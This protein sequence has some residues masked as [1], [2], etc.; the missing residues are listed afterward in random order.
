M[1]N[2]NSFHDGSSQNDEICIT[3]KM[4]W[5]TS[6]PHSWLTI[7]LTFANLCFFKLSYHILRIVSWKTPLAVC[8]LPH[9]S[10]DSQRR[11]FHGLMKTFDRYWAHT[12]LYSTAV[13][14]A[15][16][17]HRVV[18]GVKEVIPHCSSQALYYHFFLR[19]KAN[20]VL[21]ESICVRFSIQ[22]FT[23]LVCLKEGIS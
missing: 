23:F 19:D 1:S 16:F 20:Q 7:C 6:S 3:V 15:F 4:G 17:H 14:F 18:S 12:H 8:I 21:R 2:A 10:R 11:D 22:M 13:C 9:R 5:A